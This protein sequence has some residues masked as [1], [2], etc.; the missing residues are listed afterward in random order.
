MSNHKLATQ[1]L[2]AGQKI[3]GETGARAVPV[4]STT[5]YVFNDT[6]HAADLF[7]LQAFGNIYSRLGNPT[8]DVLEQRIAA[9]DGGAAAVAFAS[10]M[11][12]ITAVICTLAA[13][14]ENIVSSASLY[15]GTRTLFSHTLPRLGIESRF[16][17]SNDTDAIASLIDEKTKAVYIE[18]IG[19]PKND[20]P[21]IEKIAVIARE[22]GIPLIVDNTIPTPVQCR[23]LEHGAD[24]VVY[25]A[26]KYLGG[27]GTHIAGVVVDSGKFDWKSGGKKWAQ[28]NDPDPSYHGI[29]FSDHFAPFGNIVLAAHLRTHWLRDTGACLSPWGAFLILQGIETLHL[30]VPRHTENAAKVAA[31]LT[32]HPKI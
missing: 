30:R 25:S 19:N 15:G 21:D 13:T 29:V 16:F 17:D 1:A 10:G 9:L 27:H 7:A 6:D 23:P 8:V 24:I 32:T 4:Y 18:T 26:T 2:H 11:A 31:W 5:S 22:Y 3:D 14:G 20:I 28:F 12:A